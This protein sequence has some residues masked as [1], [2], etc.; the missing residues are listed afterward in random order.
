MSSILDSI[1]S[2]NLQVLEA[3][4]EIPIKTDS[5]SDILQNSDIEF[6]N[7]KNCNIINGDKNSITVNTGFGN[8][9]ELHIEDHCDSLKLN[10]PLYVENFLREFITEEQKA[11]ARHALGIYNKG[12]VVAMSLLTAEISQPSQQQWKEATNKQLRMGD[13]FFTPFTKFDAVF[14]SEG[15]NLNTKFTEIQNALVNQAQEI[16][17]LK[18]PS[19]LEEITS[20]GDVQSFLKG[21]NNKDNL[22]N[23]IDDINQ[24][25]LRFDKTGII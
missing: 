14:N 6:E 4:K 21:F 5:I 17:K 15:Q 13:Q 1:L 18:Q 24:E 20:L 19:N 16:L 9:N 23:I 2:G 11:A 25:M 8:N 22:N 3:P 12:D 7:F 10:T